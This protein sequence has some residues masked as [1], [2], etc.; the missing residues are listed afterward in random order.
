VIRFRVIVAIRRYVERG[1]LPDI[2]GDPP[3]RRLRA[4]MWPIIE[5]LRDY[6]L[7]TVE[8]PAHEEMISDDFEL[9]SDQI[10]PLGFE[11]FKGPAEKYWGNC[12]RSPG[13]NPARVKRMREQ[14]LK[15][16]AEF[17]AKLS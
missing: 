8:L 1:A 14:F 13:R 5:I 9:W 17:E 6:H 4:D 12:G 7:A 15:T 16:K 3:E 10:T 2:P 11:F